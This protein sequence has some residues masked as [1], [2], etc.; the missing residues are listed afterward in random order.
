[1]DH[2]EL[3]FRFDAVYYHVSDMER[4]IA[5]YRDVLGF[6]LVSRDYVARFDLDGVLFELV[7][8]PPGHTLPGDGNARLCL[9][10]NDI[11]LATRELEAKGVK[12]MPVEKKPGG[13][14]SFFNDP[15]GNEISLWQ[16]T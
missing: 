11:R 12:T 1:M 2:S 7:P 16:Y 10:M 4:S 15:D 6:Q 14:L 9:G 13:L 8:N 3:K 5:F